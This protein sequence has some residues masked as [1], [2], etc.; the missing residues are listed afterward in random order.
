MKNNKFTR[1]IAAV[2]AMIMLLP[3][4][5]AP[6]SAAEGDGTSEQVFYWKASGDT[7]KSMLQVKDNLRLGSSRATTHYTYKIKMSSGEMFGQTILGYYLKATAAAANGLPYKDYG[8]SKNKATEGLKLQ[9]TEFDRVITRGLGAMNARLTVFDTSTYTTI[10]ALDK[11]RVQVTVDGENWLD[12][13]GIRSWKLLGDGRDQTAKMWGRLIEIQT[14]NLLDI[15]GLKEGDRIVGIRLLPYGNYYRAMGM[16]VMH[17]FEV[18]SFTTKEA[19]DKAVERLGP[20]ATVLAMPYGGSTLPR[21]K[22]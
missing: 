7:A 13:A 20:D 5:M 12:G 17:D 16:F 9:F 22:A 21:A 14:E 11:L 6:I 19:F 3:C 1:L 2:L 8:N 18:T 15:P 4:V 10:H